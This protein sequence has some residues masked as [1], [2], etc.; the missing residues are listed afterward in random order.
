MNSPLVLTLQT[1]LSPS[2][3]GTPHKKGSELAAGLEVHRHL[4]LPPGGGGN[5]TVAA[6]SPCV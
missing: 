5:G 3:L 1:R 6:D 4:R 2:E